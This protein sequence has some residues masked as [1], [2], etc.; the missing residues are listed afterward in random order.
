MT[1]AFRHEAGIYRGAD[2][3]VGLTTSFLAR[4]V[5][6]GEPALV[7]VDVDR[8]DRLRADLGDVPTVVYRDIRTVGRNPALLL[9]AWVDFVAANVGAPALWGVGE[10]LWPG[11]SAFEVVECH[12]QEALLNAALAGEPTLRLLCPVDAGALP[13]RIVE[14][15][16]QCHP[17]VRAAG[18]LEHN[19]GYRPPDPAGLLTAPLP[20]PPREA[21]IF[22]FTAGDLR[23]LR[24]R[25]GALA[26]SVGLGAERAEDL[27]L[28]VDEVATNSHRHGGGHGTLLTWRSPGWLVCEVRDAGRFT[29]PMVGRRSPPSSQAGGR[30]LWIAN[31]LCDVVQVRSSDAGAVVRMYARTGA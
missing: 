2:E 26:T 30:G 25:V 15:S 20:P 31:Q 11:R 7:L 18:G 24:R 10:P 27:V 14:A 3:F 8:A 9:A 12:Q 1:V 21:A 19:A 5:R 28:A 13:P 6:T 4:A 29:D 22:D 16:L 23:E 17:W